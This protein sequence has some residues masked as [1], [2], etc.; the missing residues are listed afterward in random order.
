MK[1]YRVL[2]VK[3]LNL[4]DSKVPDT[5]HQLSLPYSS[6]PLRVSYRQRVS[7][8]KAIPLDRHN[9]LTLFSADEFVMPT[10]VGPKNMT[11]SSG[12]AI[13]KRMLRPE[14]GVDE[15]DV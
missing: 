14:I 8:C 9:T 12:C 2:M 3:S 6:N 5:L 7:I 11:S 15:E 13:T 1:D 4:I 10:S